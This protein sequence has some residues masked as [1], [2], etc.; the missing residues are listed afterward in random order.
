[1]Y[2][3]SLH[4]FLMS[5]ILPKDVKKSQ[6]WI[7]AEVLVLILYSCAF[8]FQARQLLYNMLGDQ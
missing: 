7:K 1:M 8:M 5:I 4:I 6:N 2:L 3:E